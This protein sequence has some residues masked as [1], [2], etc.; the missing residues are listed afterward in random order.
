[1]FPITPAVAVPVPRVVCRILQDG[2][3]TRTPLLAEVGPDGQ[4]LPPPNRPYMCYFVLASCAAGFVFEMYK[5][6]WKFAPWK[7]N[8]LIGPT[9]LALV[10]SGAKDTAKIVDDG[11]G[12]RLVTTMFLHA[13]LIH[14]ALNMLSVIR[15]MFDFER[16]IGCTCVVAGRCSLCCVA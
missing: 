4:F 8:P 15:C 7:Q 6:N 13:G 3:S 11:Q 5:S 9:A 16:E 12:W 10:A 1:M 14:F 2:A